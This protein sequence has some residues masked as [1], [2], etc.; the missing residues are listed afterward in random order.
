MSLRFGQK[1]N[2]VYDNMH[3]VVNQKHLV[4]NQKQSCWK[5]PLYRWI[6]IHLE[7]GKGALDFTKI[8][9]LAESLLL[10]LSPVDS[11]LNRQCLTGLEKSDA[12]LKKCLMNMKV[13]QPILPVW[14][15]LDQPMQGLEQPQKMFHRLLHLELRYT[16]PQ[17]QLRGQEDQS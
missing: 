8:P 5:K 9:S 13:W 10:V 3:F 11:F 2:L 12:S 7:N 6:E 17:L 14:Q 1:Q 15:P 4:L 16:H